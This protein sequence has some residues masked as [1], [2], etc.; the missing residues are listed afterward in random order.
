MAA[1][2]SFANLKD[3]ALEIWQIFH[4]WDIFAEID[5]LFAILGRFVTN[6]HVD[7]IKSETTWNLSID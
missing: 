5:E 4:S 2:M 7:S 6:T 3:I 1:K